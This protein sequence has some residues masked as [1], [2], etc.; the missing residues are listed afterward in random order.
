M[1]H[2]LIFLHRF[3][4]IWPVKVGG[5]TL[6]WTFIIFGVNSCKDK[7]EDPNPGGGISN[8]ATKANGWTYEGNTTFQVSGADNSYQLILCKVHEHS[9]GYT[10]IFLGTKYKMR[11]YNGSG[12]GI[13][14]NSERWLINAE[15]KT[16][17]HKEYAE[18]FNESTGSLF[19]P[20]LKTSLGESYVVDWIPPVNVS[21][22]GLGQ[23]E[24]STYNPGDLLSDGYFSDKQAPVFS[25]G[26]I[27]PETMVS[28]PICH[29]NSKGKL[30]QTGEYW[31]AYNLAIG[32]NTR[33]DQHFILSYDWDSAILR[34]SAVTPHVISTTDYKEVLATQFLFGKR[35]QEIIPQWNQSLALE[36]IPSYYQYSSGFVFAVQ[37]KEQLFVLQ[38]D[39]N[40]LKFNV[41]G[42]YPQPRKT[43]NYSRDTQ[44]FQWVPSDFSSLLFTERNIEGMRAILHKDGKITTIAL[45]EF[46][47]IVV[48]GVMDIKV[49]DGQLWMIIAD[50]NKNIYLYS[51]KL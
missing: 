32:H 28:S 29:L 25:S 26:S 6:I 11:N 5:I 31:D 30:I 37:N 24:F 10:D 51:K 50:V 16:T 49:E 2:R 3:F 8:P 27:S 17:R 40:A 44:R 1:K 43:T 18:E 48:K 19:V 41:L 39:L 36:M 22:F 47:E 21:V 23:S 9:S 38:F 13:Y 14:I 35:I 34:V 15:G 4:R 12:N 20:I 46:K 33:T 7:E 45:P 42:S